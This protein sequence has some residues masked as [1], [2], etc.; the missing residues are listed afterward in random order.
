MSPS[1]HRR[2]TTIAHLRF[3]KLVEEAKQI[4]LLP[5]SKIYRLADNLVTCKM[6]SKTDYLVLKGV[7]GAAGEGVICNLSNYS[8]ASRSALSAESEVSRAVKRLRDRGYITVNDSAN[9]KRHGDFGLNTKILH[10]RFD[11]LTRQAALFRDERKNRHMLSKA[12]Q[13]C[14]RRIG[15]LI[16]YNDLPEEMAHL[17][18]ET[19]G[20]AQAVVDD[21]KMTMAVVS[22]E[23]YAKAKGLMERVI[24]E[25]LRYIDQAL[26]TE[27]MSC[28]HD[29]NAMDIPSTTLNPSRN[30][31]N[32]MK[33][34]NADHSV[35]QIAADGVDK[36][37]EEKSG[38][39]I[40]P[41]KAEFSKPQGSKVTLEMVMQACPSIKHWTTS[42]IRGWADLVRQ[43]D[44]LAA[45]IG[46]HPSA[47]H[48]ARRV[49]G[50]EHAAV[51]MAIT[52]QKT[53]DPD[54]NRQVKQPGGY[55]RGMIGKAERGEL[56]L[57]RSIYG[58]L[59][60]SVQA[61]A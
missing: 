50:Q 10:V 54:E 40:E 27:E 14:K 13:S 42:P 49:L 1:I 24:Q 15:S 46:V 36:G 39:E 12:Y 25:A 21:A 17:L 35:S 44:H 55:I 30:C 41:S 48:E 52:L 2:K 19:K 33:S 16:E 5:M 58:L 57:D 43:T 47:V 37:F 60:Q 38:V 31:N 9:C 26:V 59:S 11:E 45:C 34:A 53:D 8:L 32:K 4:E 7:I 3:E 56:R 20:Q 23:I 29:K 28:V 61:S 6:I 51:A 22:S 18:Y